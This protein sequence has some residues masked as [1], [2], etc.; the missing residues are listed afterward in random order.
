L[1][2]LILTN[3]LRALRKRARAAGAGAWAVPYLIVYDL[4]ETGAVI[5]GGVRYRTPVL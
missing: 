5:R 1:R 4:I 2:R 3:H